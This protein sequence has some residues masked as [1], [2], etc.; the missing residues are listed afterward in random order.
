MAS[1]RDTDRVTSREYKLMLD[2]RLFAIRDEAAAIF[3]DDLARCTSSIDLVKL[4]GRF[5]RISKRQITFLDTPHNTIRLN[6]W[7]LRQRNSHESD[8]TEYTLKCRSPDYY[9]AREVDVAAGE[10]LHS[11]VKLEEDIAAPFAPRYSRSCTVTGTSETPKNLKEASAIFPVLGDLTRDG[12]RSH[13][14]VKLVPTSS[15]AIFERVL[16][17]PRLKIA[18]VEAEIALI[19]WSDQQKRRPLVAEFSFRYAVPKK[20]AIGVTAEHAM[21]LFLAIQR[22]DWCLTEAR[23]KTQY[24]YQD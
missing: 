8:S 23:T 13:G 10:G 1:S 19:L 16:T 7:V 4:K 15:V 18:G 20:A 3:G 12:L 22:L 21:K 2:H 11:R 17:G 5:D 24:A 14:D 9:L 6:G